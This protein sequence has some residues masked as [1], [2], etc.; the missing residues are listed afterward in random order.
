MGARR[1][2]PFVVSAPSGTGKTT[3]CRAVVERDPDIVFSISHT[4][5]AARPGERDGVDY[6]FV[7]SQKFRSLVEQGAFV[8]YAEYAGNLYGTSWAAIDGPLAQGQDL[9]LEID[10]QGAGQIH[11]RRSDARFIFLLPPSRKALEDRLRLRGSDSPEAI[12][13]R[14]ALS[15]REMQAVHIF[16]YAV[17]N[18][19]LESCIA[20]V[21]AIVRGEREGS[22]ADLLARYGRAVTVARLRD[23]LGL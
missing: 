14:L 4:T 18:E 10:V 12:E 17:V 2:I 15:R 9:L 22:T 6:H 19:E 21:L 3:V 8:E 7:S 13:R 20:A 16:D 5:R 23:S 1:G 11:E